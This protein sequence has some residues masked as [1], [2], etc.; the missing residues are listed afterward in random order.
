MIGPGREA[1]T[2]VKCEF[3]RLQ[4]IL[5]TAQN[6]SKNAP[7]EF[8]AAHTAIVSANY[9]LE[10]AS[11]LVSD[12]LDGSGSRI[13]DEDC[14]NWAATQSQRMQAG[15]GVALAQLPEGDGHRL[16]FVLTEA[17]TALERLIQHILG[18]VEASK[19]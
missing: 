19:R 1:A 5:G 17:Q 15:V 8:S 13:N 11:M 6:I 9:A 10:D 18:D 3:Y 12:E 4:Y 2:A 7:D 14:G 16:R